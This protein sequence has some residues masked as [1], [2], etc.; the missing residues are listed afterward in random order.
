MVLMA[1]ARDR[2]AR[3]LVAAALLGLLWFAWLQGVPLLERTA[4]GH[5]VLRDAPALGAVGFLHDALHLTGVEC[6]LLFVLVG[7]LLA[8]TFRA[9]TAGPVSWRRRLLL[10]VVLPSVGAIGMIWIGGIWALATFRIP[11]N[12]ASMGQP[13]SAIAN[14]LLF[15]AE[16]G[17]ASVYA[18]L[19]VASPGQIVLLPMSALSQFVLEH[20]AARD[21]ARPEGPERPVGLHLE[22]TPRGAG[23]A[24]P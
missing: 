7:V 6:A 20:V 15:A 23:D 5:R 2:R 17:M 1:S 4:G 18:A 21:P 16:L 9:W 24:A 10:I 22:L 11:L 13:P 14:V 12:V 19:L 3:Y 8:W